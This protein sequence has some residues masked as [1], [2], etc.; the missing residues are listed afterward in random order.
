MSNAVHNRFSFEWQTYHKMFPEQDR[1]LLVGWIYPFKPDDFKGKRVLDMGCGNG[2]NAYWL[3]QWGADVLG[4]DLDEEIV[5]VARKNSGAECV[6]GNIYDF[7]GNFDYIVAIG[8]V[9]HLADP[10]RAIENMSA[11]LNKNGKFVFWCYGK[12]GNSPVIFL[13]RMMRSL[14]IPVRILHFLTYFFS[15]PFWTLMKTIRVEGTGWKTY[16]NA[17]SHYPFWYIHQ[18]IFD[19]FLPEYVQYWDREDIQN[20][21]KGFHAE[22]YPHRENGWNVVLSA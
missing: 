10:R 21:T 9:H 5:A 4:V 20:L 18:V 14:N 15:I 1:E 7:K 6:V 13:T 3:K 2:R 11:Q 22:I 19:Q 16:L 12:Q 8:V 17:R